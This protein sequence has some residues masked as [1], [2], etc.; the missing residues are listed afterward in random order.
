M[1]P[2]ALRA[3][4]LEA[5]EVSEGHDPQTLAAMIDETGSRVE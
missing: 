5:R 2:R 3:D 1:I 4:C